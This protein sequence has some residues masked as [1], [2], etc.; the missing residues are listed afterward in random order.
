MPRIRY[1][2]RNIYAINNLFVNWYLATNFAATRSALIVPSIISMIDPEKKADTTLSKILTALTAGLAFLALPAVGAAVPAATTLVGAI[3]TT[4]LQQAPSVAQAIWPQGD[5]ASSQIVQIGDLQAELAN[6]NSQIA[7]QLNAGLSSIMTDVHV[8]AQFA[9]STAFSGQ[10]IPSLP[11]EAEGLD[12][13]FKT[14]LVTRAMA[15]N[16]WLA[17]WGPPDT[18]TGT[19][20]GTDANAS[21]WFNSTAESNAQKFVCNL[22]ANGVC[23][24]IDSRGVAPLCQPE[25]WSEYTSR[26]SHRAY[27]P[28][29]AANQPTSA[30]LANAIADKGWGSLEMVFDGGYNCSSVQHHDGAAVVTVSEQGRLDFSCLSQL[31]VQDGCEEQQQLGRRKGW[32]YGCD[33][34]FEKRAVCKGLWDLVPGFLIS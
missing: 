26:T 33:A 17:Y 34:F 27:Y 2:V 9:S 18:G 32:Q 22:K 12:L 11:T 6:L 3:L 1:V 31:R 8:F 29:H 7:K 25:D 21:S 14:Y 5:G 30:A 13:A 23:D 24:T 10:E 28:T 15:A 20:T 16:E 19:G 4:S